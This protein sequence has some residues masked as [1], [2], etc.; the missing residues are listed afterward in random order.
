MIG[1][2]PCYRPQ[3]VRFEGHVRDARRV[4]NDDVEKAVSEVKAGAETQ[5]GAT[6][7]QPERSKGVT[8]EES[9]CEHGL[10]HATPT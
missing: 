2:L 6:P 9:W 3:H 7:A 10:D 8:R 4:V 5:P 1:K